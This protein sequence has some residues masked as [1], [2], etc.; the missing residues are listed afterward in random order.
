MLHGN[1]QP[2]FEPMH[3]DLNTLVPEGVAK[4]TWSETILPL[5]LELLTSELDQTRLSELGAIGL[6]VEFAHCARVGSAAVAAFYEPA[7]LTDVVVI[8]GLPRTGT[9]FVQELLSTATGRR[10]LRGWEAYDP[11]A[12]PDPTQHARAIREARDRFSA[13]L[14]VAPQLYAMHPLSAEGLEECTPLLQHS[15][16]CLQWAMMFDCPTYLD[17]LLDASLSEGYRVWSAQLQQIDA[18][19]TSWLLKSPMHCCDYAGLYA[20]APS[21]KLIHVRRDVVEVVTSFLN[22]CLEARRVFATTVDELP[23]SLGPF[24]LPRLRR[25]LDR[26]QRTLD[27]LSI[28]VVEVDYPT[29][30]A[31]PAR[32]TAELC[33]RLDLRWS[34]VQTLPSQPDFAGH[35]RLSLEDFG[36]DAESVRRVL[37]DHLGGQFLLAG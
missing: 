13:A 18:P 1:S 30:V 17:S 12:V 21:A 27:R 23:Q 29:L 14:A 36:I 5:R 24:W 25:V 10:T 6:T 33:E 4:S 22:L 3:F 19:D 11:G 32:T 7:P 15:F 28:P 37:R 34:G 8:G 31:N 26:A 9:T 35:Q 16:E 20:A 2:P